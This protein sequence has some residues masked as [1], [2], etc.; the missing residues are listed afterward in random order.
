MIYQRTRTNANL[1]QDEAFLVGF[2]CPPLMVSKENRAFTGSDLLGFGI[3]K[4]VGENDSFP[5]AF[6]NV[7]LPIKNDAF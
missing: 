6:S 1:P 7:S 2:S 5:T 4:A 3:Y